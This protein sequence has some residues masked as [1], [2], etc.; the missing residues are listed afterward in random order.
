M[1]KDVLARET[2]TA[3]GLLRRRIHNHRLETSGFRDPADV[4]AWMGAVQAQDYPAAKWALGLRVP[5]LTDEDVERAFAEGRILRTHVLRPTWHFVAPDDIRWMLELTGPRVRRMNAN[6]Y[7]RLGLD[8]ALVARSRRVMERALRGGKQLTRARI[9]TALRRAG[10]AV[11]RRALAHVAMD[12]E[13][14]GVVCSGAREGKQFTY[15]L[16]EERA[17][18]AKTLTK[19]EAL[20]ELTRRY[21]ASHGPA[22]I[23]DYVWWSGL[24]VG[25]A[26]RGIDIVGSGLQRSQLGDDTHWAAPARGAMPAPVGAHLLPNY[27]EYLIAYRD[28]GTVVGPARTPPVGPRGSDVFAHNLII[29]GRLAGSWTRSHGSDGARIDV[30]SYRRPTPGDRRAI[31]AAADRYGKFMEQQVIC[32]QGWPGRPSRP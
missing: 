9:G 16:L 2:L 31:A 18:R 1:S 5:G 14:N 8:D 29:E 17:P 19:D 30:A 10:I 12:A 27:D 24:A 4:V 32:V 6:Y 11:D 13:L 22:T 3:A 23:R 21:F 28:R 20:A 7:R 15:A 25:D 26:R